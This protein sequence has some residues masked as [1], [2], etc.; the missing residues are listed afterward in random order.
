MSLPHALLTALVERPSSGFDLAAR[1][2]K[3]I[4]YFWPASHQQIYRELARLEEAGWVRSSPDENARGG[5]KV[6]EVLEAGREALRR[7]VAEPSEPRPLREELM[8]KLRADAAV[9]PCGLQEVLLRR[10]AGHQAQLAEYLAIEARDFVPGVGNRA[11]RLQHLVL[12]AG[13]QLE[14]MW[15]GFSRQALEILDDAGEGAATTAPPD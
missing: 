15:I 13:I 14:T 1:F 2:D 4:A 9:G 10:L 5:R 7:W 8:I 12:Q 3:S 11:Q 6:Y